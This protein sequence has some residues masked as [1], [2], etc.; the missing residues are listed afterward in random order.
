MFRR[1]PPKGEKNAEASEAAPRGRDEKS[2]LASILLSMRAI[3]REQLA[4]ARSIREEHE[5]SHA[6]MLLAS[7]LRS[8]GFCNSD[9]VSRALQI[10]N[11]MV[12][13]ERATVALDLM[14]ERI[15]RYRAGEEQLHEEISRSR[16]KLRERAEGRAS[17]EP[18]KTTVVIPFS[19]ATAKA[20]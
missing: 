19:P 8:M 7:T 11:R 20:F 13:G 1:K 12:Q 15:A 2:T 9:D 18:E 3:T 17:R 5:T 14:E 4:A 6:D 10:Q 16:E